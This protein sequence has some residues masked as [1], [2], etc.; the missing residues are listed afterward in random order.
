M[1]DDTSLAIGRLQAAQEATKDEVAGLKERTESM[2]E[3]LDKLLAR[4]DRLSISFKHWLFILAGGS[5]G[6]GG[7]AH[8]LKKLLGP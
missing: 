3:K 1:L 5:V 4:T 7:V 2:D 8:L 6:G